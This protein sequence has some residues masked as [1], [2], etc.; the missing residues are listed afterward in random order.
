MFK[1]CTPEEKLLLSTV[2]IETDRCAATGFFFGTQKG[3]GDI[4]VTS[5]HAIEG[6]SRGVLRIHSA[7]GKD[8]QTNVS[9][10]FDVE[11][12]NFESL[13]IRHPD[14][15]I[16]LAALP[17]QIIDDA[18]ARIGRSAHWITIEPVMVPTA[19]RL[20]ELNAVEDV[21]MVGYP[22]GIWD[23]FNNMP[24]YCRG[25]TAS[26]PEMDFCGKPEL[27]VDVSC[28]P[29]SSGSPVFVINAKGHCDNQGHAR[30]GEPQNLLLG[31]ASAVATI[32]SEG[33]IAA[34]PASLTTR[35]RE[36]F[37]VHLTYVIK[38][39][40]LLRFAEVIPGCRQVVGK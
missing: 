13:W 39:R 2:R 24:I 5:R 31:V 18:A 36:E 12:E 21:L 29:G 8:Q 15:S 20:L 25:I 10:T 35:S 17:S 16:D 11:L 37:V 14:P 30:C 9:P 38:S 32:G 33:Q 26:H 6:S 19:A 3:G 4:L 27:L 1:P 28:F 34:L 22:N 7:A 40:E 23:Q